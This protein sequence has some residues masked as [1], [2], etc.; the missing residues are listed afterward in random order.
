MDVQDAKTVALL[1]VGRHNVQ[2][3][4]KSDEGRHCES[5]PQ[6]R[7]QQPR[8]A[9]KGWGRAKTVKGNFQAVKSHSMF[10]LSAAVAVSGTRVTARISSAPSSPRWARAGRSSAAA[11][12]EERRVGKVR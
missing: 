7:R 1:I 5:G 2:G 11:R 6:P 10:N 3:K 4:I 8:Q 9:K 12:S